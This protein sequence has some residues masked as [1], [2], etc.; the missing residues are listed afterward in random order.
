ML[1]VHKSVLQIYP[2]CFTVPCLQ[3]CSP[4]DREDESNFTANM[5]HDLFAEVFGALFAA[6]WDDE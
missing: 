2:E 3:P 4:G 6:S 1:Y 5:A